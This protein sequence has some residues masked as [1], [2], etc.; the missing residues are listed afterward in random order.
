MLEEKLSVIL[1]EMGVDKYS[2]VLDSEVAEYD[3]TDVYMRSIS[4]PRKIDESLYPVESEMK[5]QMANAKKYKDIIREDKDLTALVGQESD[6]DIED[7]LRMVLGYYSGWQGEQ[8]SLLDRIG[9]NDEKVTRHLNVEIIQDKFSPL[10]SVGIKNF[11]NEA[12][13]FMLWELS[14]SDGRSERRIIPIFINDSFVLRPVAGKRIMDVFLDPNSQLTVKNV[15][16]ISTDDYSKLEKMSMDF[17]YDAFVDLR[18]KQMQRNQESYNKYMYA[19]RLRTEAAE[20]I[21]IENI[22]KSRLARFQR[23]K[24][25]IEQNYRNGQKVYPDFRLVILVRLEA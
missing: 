8:P 11:P 7:A 15:R 22:K 10:L 13:Y 17:S 12:G 16:N 23:E 18:E 14:I 6:F 1:K 25:S 4:H 24:E 21:G 3:F 20:Q 9:I 2:D 5:Q 19:L